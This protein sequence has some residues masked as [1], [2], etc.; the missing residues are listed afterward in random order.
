MLIIPFPAEKC[1]CGCGNQP[2][3]LIVPV[4]PQRNHCLR[5]EQYD[6]QVRAVPPSGALTWVTEHVKRGAP[7]KRVVLTGP[8]DPLAQAEPVL[9]TLARL[10]KDFPEMELVLMTIG[11]HA[12]EWAVQ[13]AEKGLSRVIL[14]ISALD[15]EIAKS[16]FAWIR[17]AR[18]TLPLSEAVALLLEAQLKAVDIF[19]DNSLPVEIL[20]TVYPGYNDGQ[21][22]DIARTL[23]EKG[24]ERL[25]LKPYKRPVN[26]G[27]ECPE[28]P[29]AAHMERLQEEAGNFLE[30]VLCCGSH[31]TTLGME[32]PS[33]SGMCG[34]TSNTKLPR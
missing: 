23:A 16:L 22:V 7:I 14:E 8:G 29:D 25:L 28:E 18:K 24:V 20:T 19:K 31:E 6:P 1:G 12:D 9:E 2:T 11:L 27:E 33:V 34:Q 15:A 26:L 5:F 13:L 17:P 4:A 21:I 30:T 32:C 3:N 10:R